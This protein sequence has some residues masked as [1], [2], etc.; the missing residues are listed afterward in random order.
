MELV[1][2]YCRITVGRSI[3]D[4]LVEVKLNGTDVPSDLQ[5]VQMVKITEISDFVSRI[6]G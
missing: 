1:G 2:A 5:D 4:G 6:L 3:A